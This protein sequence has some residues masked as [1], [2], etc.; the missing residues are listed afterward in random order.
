MRTEG[1]LLIT[2][3]EHNQLGPLNR[4]T[5][6]KIFSLS[7]ELIVYDQYVFYKQ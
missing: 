7:R 1:V 3:Y 2:F 5:L 4:E 6:R